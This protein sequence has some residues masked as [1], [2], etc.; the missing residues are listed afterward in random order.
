MYYILHAENKVKVYYIF[1]TCCNKRI[2][3]SSIYCNKISHNKFS[4]SKQELSLKLTK[5]LHYGTDLKY[6]EF[7]V[8][9]VWYCMLFENYYILLTQSF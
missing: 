9:Y 5:H 6:V 1:E 8:I 3:I 7:I 4:N 2:H